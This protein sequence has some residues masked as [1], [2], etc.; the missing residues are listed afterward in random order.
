LGLSLLQLC[1]I[2]SVAIGFLNLLPVPVLDGGALAFFAV[3]AVRGRP[4]GP[5]AQNAAYLVGLA[6]V[7]ILFLFA[8]WNDVQRMLGGGAG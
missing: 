4:L 2:L 8:T 1:A 7:A 3:E 5:Q 6:L